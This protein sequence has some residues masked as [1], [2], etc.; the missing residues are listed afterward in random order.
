MTITI[1]HVTGGGAENTDPC[2]IT[3][4]S[5]SIEGNVQIAVGMERSGGNG[6]NFTITGSGWTKRESVTIT[7]TTTRRSMAV[8]TRVVGASESTTITIDDGTANSKTAF[9]HEY[10]HGSGTATWT[11]EDSVSNDNGT[12]QDATSI[13]TGTTASISAGDLLKVGILGYKKGNTSSSI[14]SS[15]TNSLTERAQYGISEGEQRGLFVGDYLLDTSSGTKESTV[16]ISSAETSNFGLL[17]ALVVFSA[18][19]SGGPTF[20]P[21]SLALSGVG[22]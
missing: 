4:S 18:S 22:K 7:D 17:S 6:D 8:W 14:S 1:A 10:Q 9:V 2:S 3:L 5:G 13:S 15:W 16:T 11:F 12:T 20:P 19:E 21:N